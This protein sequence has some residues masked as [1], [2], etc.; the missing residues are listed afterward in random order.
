MKSLFFF[1]ENCTN[2][3][4]PPIRICN[5]TGPPACYARSN[6]NG[7]GEVDSLQNSRP[8]G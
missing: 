6:E 3:R 5:L 4:F 7:G 1:D 2:S 8:L